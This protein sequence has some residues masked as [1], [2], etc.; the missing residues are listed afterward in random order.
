MPH[1][2]SQTP[3]GVWI[4]GVWTEV[5]ARIQAEEEYRQMQLQGAAAVEQYDPALALLDVLPPRTVETLF[6][7][8]G[9]PGNA[10]MGGTV[11]ESTRMQLAP[12]T[13]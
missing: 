3:R 7:G 13:S 6:A 10:R 8:A 9:V 4:P 5:E 2:A 1:K 12:S 11:A